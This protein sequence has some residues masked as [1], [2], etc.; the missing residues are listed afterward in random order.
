MGEVWEKL[1]WI[2]PQNWALDIMVWCIIPSHE[3][4]SLVNNYLNDGISIKY[5]YFFLL[6]LRA[7]INII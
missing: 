7:L 6:R 3:V 2:K 5:I 4:K 1:K